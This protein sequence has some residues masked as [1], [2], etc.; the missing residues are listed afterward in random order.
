[1]KLLPESIRKSLSNLGETSHKKFNKIKVLVKFFLPGT[2]WTWYVAEYDPEED[3]LWG[4]CKSGIGEDYDEFGTMW[5][6]DLE[7]VKHLMVGLNAICNGT[8]KP[9][10]KMSW[11]GKFYSFPFF[12]NIHHFF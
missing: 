5:L 4:Y 11:M 7:P 8:P 6:H 12:T 3:I 9:H 2:R 10:C 1:M